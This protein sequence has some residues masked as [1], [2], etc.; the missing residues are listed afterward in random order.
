MSNNFDYILNVDLRT[1]NRCATFFNIAK[2]SHLEKARE[3]AG[4]FDEI[5]KVHMN[6]MLSEIR[7]SGYEEIKR[8]VIAEECVLGEC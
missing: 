3:Y 2:D 8:R 4:S 7:D 6:S 5:S 1:W